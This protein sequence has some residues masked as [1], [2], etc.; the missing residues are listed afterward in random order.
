VDQIRSNEIST[1]LHHSDQAYTHLLEQYDVHMKRILPDPEFMP[2]KVKVILNEKYF[3]DTTFYL[4]PSESIENLI[5]KLKNHYAN[6]NDPITTFDI[7]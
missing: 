5:E 6:L 3:V 1:V 2:Y 7:K 4:K